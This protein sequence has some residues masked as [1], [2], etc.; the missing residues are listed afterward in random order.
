MIE[1]LVEKLQ[2]QQRNDADGFKPSTTLCEVFPCTQLDVVQCLS[3]PRQTSLASDL[4][5][6]Y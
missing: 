3:V 4:L 1:H 2:I 6:S 5:W